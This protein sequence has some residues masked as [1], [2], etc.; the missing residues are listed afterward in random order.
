MKILTWWTDSSPYKDY[1]GIIADRSGEKWQDNC[2]GSG[3]CQLG[4]GK[5]PWAEFR[6]MW[7][8]N[9]LTKEKRFK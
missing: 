3:L 6:Y 7:K 1:D 2:N 9:R 4:N 5:I 8:N